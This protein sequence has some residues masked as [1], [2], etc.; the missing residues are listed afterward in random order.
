MKFNFYWI[1]WVFICTIL[2][3]T[4]FI[5]TPDQL[6]ISNSYE[7]RDFFSPI[8]KTERILNYGIFVLILIYFIIAILNDFT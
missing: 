5:K 1:V 4:V 2:G 8:N 7:K 6:G 3:I